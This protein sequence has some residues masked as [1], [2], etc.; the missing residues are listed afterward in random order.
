MISSSQHHNYSVVDNVGAAWSRLESLKVFSP[1]RETNTLNLV[2]VTASPSQQV[3]QR[4]F[5]T[6]TDLEAYI[7]QASVVGGTRYM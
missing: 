4:T 1:E 7:D 2:D 5:T 3:Q 6:T